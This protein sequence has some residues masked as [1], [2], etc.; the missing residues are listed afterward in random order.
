MTRQEIYNLRSLGL[1]SLAYDLEKSNRV[2]SFW[3]EKKATAEY[4][5]R[6]NRTKND[7]IRAKISEALKDSQEIQEN[8]CQVCGLSVENTDLCNW[9]YKISEGK[10]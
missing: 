10:N 4:Y 1:D 3:N 9:C 8:G 5:I 7:A 2:L 6:Q